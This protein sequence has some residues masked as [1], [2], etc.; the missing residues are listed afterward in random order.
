MWLLYEIF[1]LQTTLPEFSASD[2]SVVREHEEFIWL[3][4][5]YVENE[6]YA[7]IIV[8]TYCDI[9]HY[10]KLIVSHCC[11]SSYQAKNGSK[12]HVL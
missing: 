9:Q 12:L 4:D 1:F 6:E 10:V 8:R 11:T 5:R 2:F 7:G 3:H